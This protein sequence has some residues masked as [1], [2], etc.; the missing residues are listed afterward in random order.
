[1]GRY[2]GEC[3]IRVAN[4]SLCGDSC[5]VVKWLWRQVGKVV[6]IEGLGLMNLCR[7][8]ASGEKFKN[9]TISQVLF[10]LA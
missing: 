4:L 7:L 3:L 1:M 5:E 10:Y 8:E 6:S 9:S 2:F